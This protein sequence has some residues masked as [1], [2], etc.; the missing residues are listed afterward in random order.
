MKMDNIKV[1][2][3]HE[4]FYS[5]QVKGNCKIKFNLVLEFS[6]LFERTTFTWYLYLMRFKRYFKR[7]DPDFEHI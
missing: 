2:W 1:R 3:E 4:I 7:P 5:M 6:Y